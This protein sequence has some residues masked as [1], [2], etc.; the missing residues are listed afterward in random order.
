ME[1]NRREMLTLRRNLYSMVSREKA[2]REK[3]S[4]AKQLQEI[5]QEVEFKSIK[6][7]EATK[8]LQEEEERYRRSSIEARAKLRENHREGQQ[9]LD[10]KRIEEEKQ[11]FEERYDT[12]VAIRNE[13]KEN[14]V[15]KRK[16]YVFRNGDARRIRQ[17]YAQMQADRLMEDHLSFELKWMGEKDAQEYKDRLEKE[18][19]ESLAARN[20]AG[21]KLRLQQVAQRKTDWEAEHKSYLL[22]WDGQKD[23]EKYK[24]HLQEI[25]RASLVFR[26]RRAV[27]Q[28]EQESAIRSKELALEHE[29]YELKWAGEQDAADYRDRLAAEKRCSLAERGKKFLQEKNA[30]EIKKSEAMAREHEAYQLKWESE[31]DAR[32][33]VEDMEKARRESLAFRNHWAKCQRDLVRKMDSEK[34]F[35]EHASYQLKWEGERDVELYKKESAEQRR[36]SLAERNKERAR[37]A[38]VMEELA[39]IARE[40]E[41]ESLVLKWAGDKDAE[42][43]LEKI[44]QDR[45]ESL[46]QRGKQKQRERL[47]KIQLQHDELQRRQKDEEMRAADQKDIEEYRNRCAERDRASLE[48]RLKEARAQRLEEVEGDAQSKEIDRKNFKLDSE[49]RTDMERYLDECKRRRRLSLAFRAKEKRKHAKWKMMCDESQRSEQSRNA[50]IR[51]LDQRHTE[52][53]LQ[54]EQSLQ[55]LEAIRH[56]GCTF[57]PSLK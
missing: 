14:V 53:A 12:S 47:I 35:E 2:M 5:E 24:E 17:L 20:D 29:S 26:G 54:Q 4:R 43:Y 33:Y 27:H 7:R 46:K 50:R 10:M 23:A 16:S 37:H 41:T 9:K 18:R 56:L 11:L 13:R 25:R 36:I 28:R 19:R 3:A 30:E 34:R 48:Y 21:R 57:N 1:K 8:N 15:K 45:R 55:V 38:K 44:A 39:T 49:A 22:K 52:L 32:E 51:L 40:K 42:K 6:Y 31:R